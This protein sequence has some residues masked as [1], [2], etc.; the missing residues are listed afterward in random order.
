[1]S[2]YLF[3]VCSIFAVC[4]LM[5]IN[6]TVC[7]TTLSQFIFSFLVSTT[8]T[9]TTTMTGPETK[10]GLISQSVPLNH[11]AI[12][13]LLLTGLTSLA[14]PTRISLCTSSSL[15]CS[16]SSPCISSTRTI[17]ALFVH[18]NSS[19]SSSCTPFP[20]G[21][22]SLQACPVTYRGNDHLQNTL[23]IWG[24]RWKA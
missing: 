17:D 20:P 10:A 18:D 16:P 6:W 21:L 7:L 11:Q 15:T 24:W 3:S 19:H 23:R 9:S 4:I 8:K 2:F 14:T 1:M 13:P 12:I 5:P 22:C